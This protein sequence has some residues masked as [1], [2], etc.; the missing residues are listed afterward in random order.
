MLAIWNISYTQQ[1]ISG[2]F[3][4]FRNANDAGF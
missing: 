3:E 2:N 1:E 4:V